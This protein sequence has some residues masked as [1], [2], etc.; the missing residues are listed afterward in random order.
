M[1]SQ[2]G[3]LYAAVGSS[4]YAAQVSLFFFNFFNEVNIF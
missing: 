1:I 3:M 4:L 2:D